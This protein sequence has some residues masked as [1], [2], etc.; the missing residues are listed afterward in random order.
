MGD[1]RS[2]CGK[3]ALHCNYHLL[4]PSGHSGGNKHDANILL[5]TRGAPA[6]KRA[7]VEMMLICCV[8][9]CG[10]TPFSAHQSM[11]NTTHC[12]PPIEIVAMLH[13]SSYHCSKI[14]ITLIEFAQFARV[15]CNLYV[16]SA[17]G[18]ANILIEPIESVHQLGVFAQSFHFSASYSERPKKHVPP[19]RGT[20]RLQPWLSGSGMRA[21]FHTAC[22]GSLG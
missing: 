9:A 8:C 6:I 16:R 4:T 18:K 12:R 21:T 11:R 20:L 10:A 22:T 2:F 7:H 5:V 17:S 3:V 15:P 14:A 13:A 19:Q 1:G